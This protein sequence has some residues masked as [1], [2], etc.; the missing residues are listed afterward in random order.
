MSGRDRDEVNEKTW[1]I[2]TQEFMD[3]G[4]KNVVITLGAKGAFY[5]NIT[6]YGHCPA[7]DVQVKDTTGA[8]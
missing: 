3:W 5:A 6:G 2:I 7:F 8:E 4:V 1:L